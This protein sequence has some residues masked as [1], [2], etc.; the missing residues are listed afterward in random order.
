MLK[1]ILKRIL[2]RAKFRRV[3]LFNVGSWCNLQSEFEGNNKLGTDAEVYDCK[4]GYG[5]YISAFTKLERTSIGRYCSI[6]KNVSCVFG[7]HPTEKWV[8]THPAFFSVRKQAGFTYVDK[9][10]FDESTTDKYGIIIGNDVWIGNNALLM[11]GIRVGNGAII[12]AG[13]V[14]TKNVPPY[15][16]VGGVPAKIIRYRFTN[17]QIQKIEDI[18]WWDKD[19]TW[20]KENIDLFSDVN[21]FTEL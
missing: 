16:I 3:T 12:G 6:G 7:K 2:C 15:A 13:A 11:E 10:R 1:L 8:T 21:K 14:V 17:E 4:L 5:T 19:E 20:L 18:K 9:E